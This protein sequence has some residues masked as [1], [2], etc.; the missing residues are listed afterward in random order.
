MKIESVALDQLRAHYPAL[1]LSYVTGDGRAARFFARDPRDEKAILEGARRAAGRGLE[2]G[3]LEELRSYLLRCEAPAE[4]LAALEKL[5]RGAAAVVT[6]QQPSAGGGPLY[7][8]YKAQAAVRYARA[9]EARGVPCAAVFWNHSDDISRGGRVWFPD[10]ENLVHE[11]A[12]PPDASGTPLWEAGTPETL[13]MFASVLAEAL[14]RT[15][16]SP[17]VEEL[18]RAA[19]QGTVAETFTRTLLRLLGPSGLVV[20]E[21]R[22]LEGE[23]ASRLIA[24]HL[25]RPERLSEAVEAGRRAVIAEGFEDHLGREVGLDLFEMRP[26]RRIRLGS[27]G[28]AKGR[29]SAGVALR[30]LLQDAVLPTCA[31]VGGPSE[32][33][34][35]AELGE[36]YRA[37]GI[38]PP[39]I[40]PRVTATL[41][42]PKIARVME[43][44]GLKAA[45]LFGDEAS[46]AARIPHESPDAARA[47]R[48][49]GERWERELEEAAGE[50][51]SAPSVERAR[52]KTAAKVREALEAFS[53]RVEEEL[54]RSDLTGRGQRAKLLA[55]VRPGGKLQERVFTPFYYMSLFGPDLIARLLTTLDPFIFA[56]QVITLA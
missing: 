18:L 43:K 29:L 3:V 20:L 41:V 17:G 31:Y 40:L 35:Q 1:F 24:D 25:A 2:K 37:F 21:P 26:G 48:A 8:L 12:L 39:V 53:V 15:E 6:G 9:I 42:E 14:P 4:S 33:G 51:R 28:A 32:V 52:E 23:R 7:N 10:R 30:P 13:R 5:G 45:D 16:F 38:E 47:I 27:P 46:L 50:L 11:V 36:A 56:H 19:H 54:K 55:H 44:F 34:Y 22:H 49:L